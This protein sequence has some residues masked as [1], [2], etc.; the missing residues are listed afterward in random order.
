[1]P[2]AG[3]I[4]YLHRLPLEL[5]RGVFLEAGDPEFT[6]SRSLDTKF[7]PWVIAQVCQLFK[8][9][10]QLKPELWTYISVS[11]RPPPRLSQYYQRSPALNPPNEVSGA[12]VFANGLK[13]QLCGG[14]NKV[15]SDSQSN[16]GSL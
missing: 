12:K 9:V 11:G 13:C 14:K 3:N 10:A 8:E 4:C 6:S 2:P 15:A 16:I 7:G 1:M 5:W